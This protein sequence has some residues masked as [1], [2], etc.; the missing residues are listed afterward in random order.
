MS[1]HNL[2]LTKRSAVFVRAGWG[3]AGAGLLLKVMSL[4]HCFLSIW[5]A[6]GERSQ[7]LRSRGQGIALHTSLFSNRLP[8]LRKIEH[9]KYQHRKQKKV[10]LLWL[11]SGNEYCLVMH[12]CV[13][14]RSGTNA[15]YHFLTLRARAH[16]FTSLSLSLHFYN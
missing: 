9:V 12:C 4:L 11:N 16:H 7:D 10:K 1:F 5:L 3:C 6:A 8:R 13:E 2:R 15:G 14:N